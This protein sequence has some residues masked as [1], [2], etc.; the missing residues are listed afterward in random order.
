LHIVK[1]ELSSSL[2]RQID[3][4]S[5]LEKLEDRLGLIRKAVKK[6][7]LSANVLACEMIM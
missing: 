5:W 3:V 6:N 1:E 2:T 4:T 7:D